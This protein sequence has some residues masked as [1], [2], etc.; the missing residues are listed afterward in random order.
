M[1][2]F[3]QITIDEAKELIDG[4]NVTV[5]DIRDPAS[6]AAAH[7]ENAVSIGKGNLDEFLESANREEPLIVYCYHGNSSQGAA[8]YFSENGFREV[9]SMIGGFEEWKTVH[10]TIS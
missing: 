6:F 2:D 1:S 3:K 5:V 4:G 9:Y 7:I 8:D 10:P